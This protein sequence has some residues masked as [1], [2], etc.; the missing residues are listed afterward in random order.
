MYMTVQGALSLTYAACHDIL[1]ASWTSGKVCKQTQK[2]DPDE[3]DCDG[4]VMMIMVTQLLIIHEQNVIQG[5]PTLILVFSVI[6]FNDTLYDTLQINAW[7]I[8]Y[9]ELHE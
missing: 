6:T 1:K 3:W 2:H 5:S 8:S 9:C 4:D 7:S